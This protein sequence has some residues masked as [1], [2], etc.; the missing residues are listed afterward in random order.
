M[1]LFS[2]CRMVHIDTAGKVVAVKDKRGWKWERP[3]K[4]PFHK[5]DYIDL[6]ASDVPQPD[7]NYHSDIFDLFLVTKT[8]SRRILL[9]KF[10]RLGTAGS[11]YHDT[12]KGCADL[13]VKFTH[14]RLG[15]YNP[16]DQPLA[17]FND[18]Y[19][20]QSC[21][22]RLPPSSEFTVCSYCGGRE[23]GIV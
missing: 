11:I 21:G 7:I 15:S 13:I 20:C 22:H 2:E 8:P 16:D 23:I 14:T 4:I 19:I 5:I 1:S 17:D 3:L 6:I 9:F 10:G 18:T 12:A